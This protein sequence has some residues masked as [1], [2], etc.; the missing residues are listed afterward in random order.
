M[1]QCIQEATNQC[2]KNIIST[3]FYIF[4]IKFSPFCA[5]SSEN[6]M[7]HREKNQDYTHIYGGIPSVLKN[8]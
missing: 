4:S 7:E 6:E 5:R 8:K 1:I 2:H 3:M